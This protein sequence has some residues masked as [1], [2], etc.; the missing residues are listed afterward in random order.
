V[1]VI[2][3]HD[4]ERYRSHVAA[5]DLPDEERDELIHVVYSVLRSLIDQ[6]FGRDATSLSLSAKANSRFLGVADYAKLLDSHEHQRI[7]HDLVGAINM[8]SLKGPDAP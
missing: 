1:S 8:T 5:I 2:S 7:D 6:S 3:T 4:M